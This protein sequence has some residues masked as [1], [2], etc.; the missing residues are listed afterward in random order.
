MNGPAT[1]ADGDTA[2][3]RRHTPSGAVAAPPGAPAARIPSVSHPADPSPAPGSFRA[4]LRWAWP[5]IRPSRAAL[6]LAAVTALITLAAQAVTPLVVEAILSLG[7]WNGGL[8]TLLV[9]LVLIQVAL[10]YVLE[11]EAHSIASRVGHRL[12]TSIFARLLGTRVLHQEGLVRPSIV[13]RHT[14]DTDVLTDTLETT[15]VSGVP[16]LIRLVQSLAFLTWIEWRAGVAMT[17]ACL[18]FLIVRSGVGRGL[19]TVDRARLDARSRVSESVDEAITIAN[20][21]RGL[22]LTTWAADR[23]ARTSESLERTSIAQGT[24]LAQLATS[25]RAAGLAGLVFVVVFAVAMGGTTLAAAAAALLYIEAV[26]RSLEALPP[27]VRQLQLSLVARMRVDQILTSPPDTT[28]PT[29]LTAPDGLEAAAECIRTCRLVGIVPALGIDADEALALIARET[30]SVHVTHEPATVN[31]SLTEHLRAL[32][33]GLSGQEADDLLTVVGVSPSARAADGQIGPGGN[34]L[35]LTDR[36]RITLAMA[37]A[38][39]PST[40]LI[41]PLL[42]LR[43]PDG[44]IELLHRIAGAGP[45]NV[46]VVAHTTEIAEIMDAVA[47]VTED[48]VYVGTH[49]ELL[50]SSPAYSAV[51][52]RRLAGDQVDLTS[53]GF[54]SDAASSMHARLVME[55]YAAGDIVY[56]LGDPADRTVFIVAGRLEILTEGTG[57]ELRR[58]AV[59]GPGNHCGDLRLSVGERR[60]ETVRCIDDAV[61]RSLSRDAISAGMAGLLDRTS[62]ERRIVSALLRGGQAPEAELRDRLA[63]LSDEEFSSALALLLRDGAITVKSGNLVTSRRRATK[64]GAQGILDRLSGL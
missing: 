50:V 12:R 51:W 38:G 10:G 3:K 26:V 55:R 29:A 8:F 54:D 20:P 37:L 11:R 42:C 33:P 59:L 21:T 46:A 22:G 57:G 25:A 35:T 56:R 9:V 15:L 17:G 47:F 2:N 41:G 40:L 5:Y 6:T 48:A 36:Q 28:R 45:S 19:V 34:F 18:V 60:A 43:D 44:A 23:M 4:L 49:A 53:L 14:S 30:D 31:L 13:S 64:S 16:G 7:A 32:Q 1:A 24:R 39:R 52:E 27:W 61:I 58:V 63:D 62:A